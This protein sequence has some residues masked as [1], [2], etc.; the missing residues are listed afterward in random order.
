MALGIWSKANERDLAWYVDSERVKLRLDV[1]R[2]DLSRQ[3]DGIRHIVEAIYNEFLRAQ[4]RYAPEKYFPDQNLQKIRDPDEILKKPGEGTCL[5][6]ALLFC[7]ACLANDLLPMVIV[8]EGHALAAVSLTHLRGDWDADDRRECHLFDRGELAKNKVNELISLVDTKN[9]IA[10]EC[11]GFAQSETLPGGQPELASRKG[12]VLAFDQAISVGRAQLSN[13]K[14]EFQYALD[15]ATLHALGMLPENNP[16]TTRLIVERVGASASKYA[17]LIQE[18][19][20]LYLITKTGAVPFGGRDG[21]LEKLDRWLNDEKAESR[22]LLTACGGGGKSALLVR[23]YSR[24]DRRR[25]VADVDWNLVFLPIS[26]RTCTNQPSVFYEAIAANVAQILGQE[27]LEP[28]RDNP[29]AHYKNK[30]LELLKEADAKRKPILL[31]VDGLDEAL[32]G[33]FDP[34]WFPLNPGPQLRL[35]V[36]ARL[37]LGDTDASG[38]INRLGWNQ[39]GCARSY[40]LPALDYQGVEDLLRT[41][42]RP[43]DALASRPE[44]VQKLY[45]SS[46]GEPLLLHLYIEDLVKQKGRTGEL[47]IKDIK[48][49][50]PSLNAYFK[51]WWRSMHDSW[52]QEGAQMDE[53]KLKAYLAVL[54]CAHGRLTSEELGGLVE[55]AHGFA[56]GLCVEDTLEPLRRFIIGKGKQ[57]EDGYVFSNPNFADFFQKEGVDPPVIARTRKAFAD[58]GRETLDQLKKNDPAPLNVSPYLLRFLVKHFEDA[59]APASDFMS[60]VE[61]GW[62]RAWERREGGYWGFSGEVE[63]VRQRIA[64]NS[65]PGQPVCAWRLRCLLVE[66]SISSM[67]SAIPPEVLLECAKNPSIEPLQILHWL[68]YQKIDSRP[69]VLAALAPRLPETQRASLIQ[70]ALRIAQDIGNPSECAE[71]LAVLVPRLPKAQRVAAIRKALEAVHEGDCLAPSCWNALVRRLPKSEREPY[72]YMLKQGCEIMMSKPAYQ[73]SGAKFI[74]AL[75]PRFPASQRSLLMDEGLKSTGSIHDP[76]KRVQVEVALASRLPE[77]QRASWLKEAQNADRPPAYNRSD[78][79]TLAALAALLPEAERTSI[80][81][82]ALTATKHIEDKVGCAQALTALLPQFSEDQRS[83]LLEEALEA[84]ETISDAW[85]HGKVL[86]ALAP[87]LPTPLLKEALRATAQRVGDD[88]ERS[89]ALAELALQLPEACQ[90]APLI[91]EA[92]RAAQ[93]ISAKVF[94]LSALT[95]VAPHLPKDERTAVILSEWKDF[96]L[97]RTETTAAALVFLAPELPEFIQ[98]PFL[99]AALV[100]IESIK[101]PWYRAE[102]LVRLAPRLPAPL[103][104]AAVKVAQKINDEW[105]RA[106]ALAS[107]APRLPASTVE[108]LKSV[109]ANHEWMLAKVLAAVAPA[110]SPLPT[111]LLKKMLKVASES[112][113]VEMLRDLAPDLPAN[114]AE[115][116]WQ[117]ARHH[118]RCPQNRTGVLAALAPRLPETRRAFLLKEIVEEHVDNEAERARVLSDLVPHLPEELQKDVLRSSVFT[119]AWKH[120]S[121]LL[122]AVKSFFPLMLQLEGSGGL[123]EVGRAICETAKWFP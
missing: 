77:A 39:D 30:C 13:P 115:E 40:E 101:D 90:L 122:S 43:V 111:A 74:C 3:P 119:R 36:S 8:I 62:L 16:A 5:D 99:E 46:K 1:I 97:G 48:Q 73:E 89:R 86:A 7:A 109:E 56:P 78:I 114:L 104:K 60:I 45:D 17:A 83:H 34:S 27:E 88:Y 2:Y 38:W 49:L 37:Q 31:M 9:Y 50:A 24:L 65:E 51:Q 55:R 79:E 10:V 68:E 32:G 15:I 121:A 63:K 14:R 28:P 53:E 54:A 123:Y 93:N 18:F 94:R 33:N 96:L 87:Q 120:R 61:E 110:P 84:A 75:A 59:G 26:M 76:W 69:K 108:E 44:A 21:E 103:L 12:G 47:E 107:L 106:V 118:I 20:E 57:F 72:L 66:S 80:L 70:E 82:E 117:T 92:L 22:F 64:E 98:T 112:R 85:V 4:I 58:W 25:Q 100:S 95:A 116:A 6:L 41:T 23:W 81:E 105:P 113:S 71:V 67:G 52:K 102:L 42:G 29:E 11:T 91:K 35:L 19:V